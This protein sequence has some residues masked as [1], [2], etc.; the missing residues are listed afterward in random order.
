MFFSG[1][2]THLVKSINSIGYF[3][4]KQIRCLPRKLNDEEDSGYEEVSDDENDDDD[5]RMDGPYHFQFD[6]D[7]DDL[8]SLNSD[9]ETA[10]NNFQCLSPEEQFNQDKLLLSDTVLEEDQTDLIHQAMKLS[11][12]YEDEDEDEDMNVC[13]PLRKSKNTNE[14]DRSFMSD[15]NFSDDST[16]SN[17]KRKNMSGGPDKKK[18]KRSA[19]NKKKK[20]DKPLRRPAPVSVPQ[21]SFDFDAEIDGFN[22]NRTFQT[23]FQQNVAGQSISVRNAAALQGTIRTPI[24]QTTVPVTTAAPLTTVPVTT[25]SPLTTVPV[26][27]TSPAL[28]PTEQTRSVAAAAPSVQTIPAQTVKLDIQQV[29]RQPAPAARPAPAT[30]PA[31]QRVHNQPAN[32]FFV[33]QPFAQNQPEPVVVPQAV[34]VGQ[35]GPLSRPVPDQSVA[36][37]QQ[38]QQVAPKAAPAPVR[39]APAPVVRQNV[40]GQCLNAAAPQCTTWPPQTTTVPVSKWSQKELST[41]NSDAPRFVRIRNPDASR[42]VKIKA[43]H[44]VQSLPRPRQPQLVAPKAAPVPVKAR[45]VP[46]PAN[47]PTPVPVIPAPVQAQATLKEPVS[48]LE[49]IAAVTT[50]SLS[51]VREM[52]CLLHSQSF[53]HCFS[54]SHYH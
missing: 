30:R 31:P 42:T 53:V 51:Q 52:F 36:R 17:R 47:Q 27:T 28:A 54:V 8:M 22:L 48:T 33:F 13:F 44:P 6:S 16:T 1:T 12:I 32:T 50:S 19:S 37:P 11:E 26:T 7:D 2:K 41:V 38:P 43:V 21:G 39:V 9:N 10:F 46:A 29:V 24:F 40:A 3:N 20:N 35:L 14:N 5:D 25:A 49:P 34:R 4:A 15:E 23:S 45:P 18:R